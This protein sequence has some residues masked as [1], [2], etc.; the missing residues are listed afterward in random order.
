MPFIKS[1]NL[2]SC[3]AV[4]IAGV[5]GADGCQH[6]LCQLAHSAAQQSYPCTAERWFRAARAAAKHCLADSGLRHVVGPALREASGATTTSDDALLAAFAS[7]VEERVSLAACLST[8][9][10]QGLAEGAYAFRTTHRQTFCMW[11]FSVWR[12]QPVACSSLSVTRRKAHTLVRSPAASTA[13]ALV[14]SAFD[15]QWDTPP[16]GTVRCAMPG[17]HRQKCGGDKTR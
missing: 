7:S 5:S 13:S 16:A 2:T 17:A 4:Q 3:S 1:R 8:A 15:A 12:H 10:A 11:A 9:R 6:L 14:R